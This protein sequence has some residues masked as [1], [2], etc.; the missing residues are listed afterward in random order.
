MSS[1]YEDRHVFIVS[2]L[3]TPMGAFGGGLSSVSAVDLGA[4]VIKGA[5]NKAGVKPENVD[6]V[7]FGNVLQAN[8]GLLFYFFVFF[9]F[10]VFVFCMCNCE[11]ANIEK[12]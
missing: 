4:H 9:C 5:L 7:F 2:G 1:A 10:C 6:E 8:Q 12:L 3:R 11:T